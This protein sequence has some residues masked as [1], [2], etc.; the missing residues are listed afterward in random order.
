MSMNAN[1]IEC[2]TLIDDIMMGHVISDDVMQEEQRRADLMARVQ[3]QPRQEDLEWEEL[4]EVVEREKGEGGEMGEG[5]EK[6]EGGEIGEGGE[7]VRVGRWVRMKSNC[8][9]KR[10]GAKKG[11]KVSWYISELLS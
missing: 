6:G 5:G 10:K 11:T 1:A 9:K 7:K 4:E 2:I 8:Q 3:P